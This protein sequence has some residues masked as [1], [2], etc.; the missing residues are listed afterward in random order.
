MTLPLHDPDDAALARTLGQAG[1]IPFVMLAALLWLVDVAL[2]PWVAIALTGYAAL[3]ISFGALIAVYVTSDFSVVAVAAN[4]HS[5]KPLHLRNLPPLLPQPQ[6][7]HLR[8][9]RPQQHLP[10]PLRRPLQH[11]PPQPSMP[12]PCTS[13]PSRTPSTAPRKLPS[14]LPDE[15]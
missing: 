6:P 14:P 10:P 7:P 1:L 8:P 2:Q 13:L 15:R 11:R 9:C 3:I 12:S 4:S 5:L